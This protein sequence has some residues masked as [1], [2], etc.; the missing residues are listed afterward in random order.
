MKK[1]A[2][3]TVLKVGGVVALGVSS[4]LSA[5]DTDKTTQEFVKKLADT[6]TK[7]GESSVGLLFFLYLP[8]V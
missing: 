2:L 8:N 6:M 7:K 1:P 3:K 5:M 4:V